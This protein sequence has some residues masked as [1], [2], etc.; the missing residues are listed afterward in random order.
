MLATNSLHRAVFVVSLAVTGCVDRVI[1]DPTGGGWDD[2]FGEIPDTESDT[3]VE[4]PAEDGPEPDPDAECNGPEDCADDQTCF[5][6]TC[7]GS[8]E[9]RVSLSWDVVSDFDLH[10]R[11]P[12][13]VEIWYGEPQVA[14]G[15][16]DVDD[17][18]GGSCRND[19]GTHVEN[20]FF[21]AGAE[22][23][24]YEVWIVN[25]DGVAGGDFR[26]QVAGSTNAEF[27]GA[28]PGFTGAQSDT[29]TFAY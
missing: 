26:V 29:F 18:V 25:F 17:C 14:S 6:G 13:G 22:R 9:F 2:S 1:S 15:Y 16:L 8:G 27:D 19:D 10:V 7:V 3:A 21:N 12:S 11:T 24:T 5:E 28:L 20:V 4:I 23:G